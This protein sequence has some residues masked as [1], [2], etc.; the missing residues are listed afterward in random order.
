MTGVSLPGQTTRL[1]YGTTSVVIVHH[2]SWVALL[3][4]IA[5]WVM[6]PAKIVKFDTG[7]FR[8]ES[9]APGALET[10]GSVEK[11]AEGIHFC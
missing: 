7:S 3:T 5:D 6:K 10:F 2:E 8:I 11:V 4:L 9:V 1:S